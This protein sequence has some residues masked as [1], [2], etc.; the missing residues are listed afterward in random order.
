MKNSFFLVIP[1]QQKDSERLKLYE[2]ETLRQWVTDLPVANPGLA[3]RLFHDFI[4]EFNKTE[5]D[6]QLRIDTLETLKPNF[7]DI[8]D[9]LRARLTKA[10]FPKGENE[11]KIL[12]VV[13]S[14]EKEFTIGYWMAV[15]ELTKRTVGWFQ[16]KNT[17]LALQR[18]IKGLG[19]IAATHYMMCLPVPDWV[20]IDLHS[21]YKL[22][23]KV[24]K[25]ATKVPDDLDKPSRTSTAEESYMQV[26]LLSLT[27]PSGL[28]Q[29]EISQLYSF[30]GKFAYLAHLEKKPVGVQMLQCVVLIDEDAP[31]EFEHEEKPSDSGKMYINFSDLYKT[32]G[33]RDKMVSDAH[34]RFSAIS[35]P[36][37][38]TE[39]LPA[40]LIDYLEQR[41]IG[42]E[43]HGM[44][45]FTDRLDRFFSIGLETTYELQ[46][47]ATLKQ[48]KELEYL[49]ESSSERALSCRFEKEG[50][51]SIGSMISFR[52]VD[53]AGNKRSLGVVNKIIMPKQKNDGLDF[54]IQLIAPQIYA[55]SYTLMD[56]DKDQEHEP[57]KALLYGVKDELNDKRFIIVD[58]YSLKEQDVVKL[59]M[60][61]DEFLILLLNKK[62]IGLGYWQFECKRVVETEL[63]AI[64]PTAVVKKKGYDFI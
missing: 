32:I 27:D 58:S 20:W 19:N 10:G 37:G 7:Y 17:A 9:Y 41:W 14:I 64:K 61:Q 55:V 47:S 56:E 34:A 13:V 15:K 28:M 11:Q 33:Q 18:T 21:L 35:I 2:E 53:A 36:R 12:D 44:A 39:K 1:P 45:C 23:V 38:S 46:R 62:N 25:D 49:A 29:K 4:K 50:I 59:V 48:N 16:G 43:L 57:Q 52:K 3:T 51:I 42:T 22:S 24:K 31:P 54:E 5:M 40:E 30:L 8:E 60:P 63:D 6:V 26:L